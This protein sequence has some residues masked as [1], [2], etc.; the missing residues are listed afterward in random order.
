VA[1]APGGELLE[2][3]QTGLIKRR[4]SKLLLISTA[5]QLDSPL[6]RMRAR[7]MAQPS[8]KRI[9]PVVEARGDLH[10][11]EW[12]LADDVSI[13]DLS[14]V[15]KCNP[16]P[17]ITVA[18]LRRQRVAVP[19]TTFAQFH[20]CRWGVSEGSWLPRMSGSSWNFDGDR[21]GLMVRR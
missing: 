4:D 5:A 2:A 6:G 7:A 17:W 9:W 11:L 3:M 10:W 13:D 18:D 8:A 15:A 19:A 20:A 14:E 1:W 21:S 16:A 12:S